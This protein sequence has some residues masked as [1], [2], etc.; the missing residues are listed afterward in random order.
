MEVRMEV[1][2]TRKITVEEVQDAVLHY[3]AA[4][5][6]KEAGDL[7]RMY[8][9]DAVTFNP[10]SARAELGQ[11]AAARLEREYFIPLTHFHADITSP[12]EVQF[13]S[14]NVAVA[15][16]TY[17]SYARNLEDSIRG[18]RYNRTVQ[19]GRGTH[20]FVLN[21]DG[22]LILAHQHLSDICRTAI[23]DVSPIAPKRK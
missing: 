13:L 16:H 8:S 3:W 1:S 5:E 15:M 10:F 14:D 21:A 22:K 6:A 17:R 19:D 18:K 11:V 7:V 4:M 2:K 12:I 9:Y 23:E 20:L